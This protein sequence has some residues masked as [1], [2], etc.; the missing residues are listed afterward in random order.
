MITDPSCSLQ[1]VVASCQPLVPSFRLS[2]TLANMVLQAQGLAQTAQAQLTCRG[3]PLGLD[4][5]LDCHSC[6]DAVVEARRCTRRVRAY[7]GAVTQTSTG[8]EGF[9][10]WAMGIG[11]DA[12]AQSCVCFKAAAATSSTL[13]G[14]V[15]V[16]PRRNS[17]E[18]L[19]QTARR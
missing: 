18:A 16:M 17:M 3:V 13:V 10:A 9:A 2:V 8:A 7:V 11:L 1:P 6:C 19:T 12:P 15:N 5:Q 4:R 14:Q